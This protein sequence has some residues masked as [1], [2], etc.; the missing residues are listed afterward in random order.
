MVYLI[1]SLVAGLILL[2]SGKA[3]FGKVLY[4]EGPKARIAGLIFLVPAGLTILVMAAGIVYES[5]AT[6]SDTQAFEQGLNNFASTLSRNGLL[7]GLAYINFHS[8]S[9]ETK[10]RGG[11]LTYGM[12]YAAFIAVLL[13]YFAL[14]GFRSSPDWLR[15]ATLGISVLE[16]VSLIGIWFWKK[17][18]VFAYA[19]LVLI[20]PVIAFLN[21]QSFLP[22]ITSL[23]Q[24]LSLLL[25]LYL[26]LKPKWQF[27]E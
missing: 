20:S 2:V 22:V 6:F 25:V 10:E 14:T 24:S 16:I 8:V 1:V 26:L 11:C 23:I 7:I 15:N 3:K 19:V 13:V 27:F 12:A 18:G 4:L 5:T 17:W 9:R 21:T